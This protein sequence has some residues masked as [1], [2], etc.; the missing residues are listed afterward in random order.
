MKGIIR[1]LIISI[2]LTGCSSRF[3]KTE[4]SQLETELKNMVESD[5]IA[6]KFPEG[7]YK[8]FTNERWNDFKDSVFTDHKLK[9]EKIFDKYGFPGF[10]KVGK[11]GSYHFWLLVQHCDQYPDFQRKVLIAMDNEVKK[12]NASPHD[13]AYLYDRVKVNGGEKQL[14]GTQV[15]FEVK[16]TGRA[17]PKIGLVDSINVDSRRKE[18]DL[19]PLKDYL[20]K[21]TTMHYEMNKLIYEKMGLHEPQLYK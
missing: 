5:Q 21:M 7:K 10:D 18:Y 17:I 16:T 15:I 13:Y 8:D 11:E 12:K 20:N 19:E 14:F 2:L 1:I 3:T 6:A 4:R 9:A